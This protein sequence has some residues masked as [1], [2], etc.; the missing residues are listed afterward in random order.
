[1]SRKNVRIVNDGKPG[2]DTLV[3]D[4]DTGTEILHVMAVDVHLEANRELPQAILTMG[5]PIVDIIADAEIK[6]VCPCCGR[7]VEQ[8]PAPE[9]PYLSKGG[10]A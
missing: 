6:Q 4:A 10:G 7:P 5:L 9:S 8:Q 1:M 2:Y 3:T